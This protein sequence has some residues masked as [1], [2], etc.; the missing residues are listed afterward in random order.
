[1]EQYDFD[2]LGELMGHLQ[3]KYQFEEMTVVGG[4]LVEEFGNIEFLVVDRAFHTMY[5][6][7]N[8]EQQD[9]D[10][11]Q[12]QKGTDNYDHLDEEHQRYA[13]MDW[14]SGSMHVHHGSDNEDHD[15]FG[16]DLYSN[17]PADNYMGTNVESGS[18]PSNDN[19]Q[20]HTNGHSNDT[21]NGDNGIDLDMLLAM[22][23]QFGD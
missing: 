8:L 10:F 15:E 4:V 20:G 6:D 12:H 23:M 11:Q 19:G 22:Q 21:K 9:A 3:N 13:T 16:E 5:V 17:D 18:A 14:D 7:L 2:N 1:V